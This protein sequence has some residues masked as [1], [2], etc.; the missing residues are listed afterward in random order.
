VT[1]Y[2]PELARQPTSAEIVAIRMRLGKS[3]KPKPIKI[4]K[5]AFMHV[6]HDADQHVKAWGWWQELQRPD[7]MVK[8][9]IRLRC[10]ISGID[11]DVF[12]SRCRNRKIAVFRRILM[13]EVKALH[14][15]YS[16]TKIGRLFNRDHTTVLH[17]L[18][19]TSKAKR[20]GL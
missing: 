2:S 12:M 6:R 4:K 19:T 8:N 7:L 15:S 18:G 3:P 16:S 11:H 17:A 13:R 5:P 20:Q 1:V 14:P 10:L 9:Y